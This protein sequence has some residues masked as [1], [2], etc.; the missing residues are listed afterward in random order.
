MVF[1]IVSIYI[2]TYN[3]FINRECPCNTFTTCILRNSKAC[4]QFQPNTEFVGGKVY[5]EINRLKQLFSQVYDEVFCSFY[6]VYTC[7]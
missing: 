2:D 3:V 1:L 4:S 7:F 6:I 5:P